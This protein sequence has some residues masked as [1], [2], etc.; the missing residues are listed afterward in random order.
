LKLAVGVFV[1]LALFAAIAARIDISQ[2]ISAIRAVSWQSLALAGLSLIGAYAAKIAR[3]HLMLRSLA[4]P[5]E[6]KASAQTLLASV[7]LNNVVPFRAGDVARVFAFRTQ[8]GASASALL[9][10][11][12]LERLLDTAMLVVLAAAIT[13]PIQGRGLLP[14]GLGFLPYLSIVALVVIALI[15]IAAGPIAAHLARR[16]D[17]DLTF[18]PAPL[19]KP[20]ADASHVLARQFQGKHAALLVSLT[21]I[22]WMFEG[23]MLAALAHGFGF[24]DPVLAGYFA[25]ALATLATLIPSAPGFFGT[26]HA[27][28]IGAV[29]ILGAPP[30]QAT[31][32]A[33]IAHA[34][35]WLP[36]TLV[37][38]GCLA[39]LA[40]QKSTASNPFHE[41]SSS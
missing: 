32:F 6:A 38:L 20:L 36:L 8:I 39:G 12:L 16:G 33:I 24:A 3:W 23:G 2:V 13:I 14:D 7:A 27:A 1:T 9:P 25:C 15:A 26:F 37:G 21:G 4:L 19:R 28:A 35:L 18:I 41:V 5:I 11:M 40:T 17:A 30:D 34:I 22:A 10:L 29:S 31:A